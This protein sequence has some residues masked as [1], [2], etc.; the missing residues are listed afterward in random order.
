MDADSSLAKGAAVDKRRKKC[1]KLY[2][3]VRAKGSSGIK[4]SLSS[5]GR[6]DNMGLTSAR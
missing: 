6:N 3:K 2:C 5:N 1:L 4:F